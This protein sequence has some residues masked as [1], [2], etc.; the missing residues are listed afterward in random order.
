MNWILE[1]ED[2]ERNFFT[3]FAG[4]INGDGRTSLPEV[5]GV[6]IFFSCSF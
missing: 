3:G 2:Y 6:G 4:I 5:V 1:N